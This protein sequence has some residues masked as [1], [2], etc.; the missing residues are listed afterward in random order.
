MMRMVPEIYIGQEQFVFYNKEK[1]MLLVI[2]CG[3]TNTGF[4]VYKECQ[5]MGSWR[6]STNVNRTADEYAVW[7]SQLLAL[8][9]LKIENIKGIIIAN[10]V[11]EITFNLVT[12]CE[13]YF[14]I[15]PMIVGDPE[16]DLGIDIDIHDPKEVG[17]DRIVNAVGALDRYQG[18]MIIVDFGTATTFDVVDFDGT[19]RGGVIA[20]GINLSLEALYNAAARLPRISI[21]EP[22]NNTSRVKI[23][24]V[25]G[26]STKSAMHSGIF[27]GYIGLLEGIVMRIKQEF[28]KPMNVIATG[29]LANIFFEKTD[30]ID[31]LDE[32]I[33]NA[34]LVLI[35]KRNIPW[36]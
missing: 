11:P 14:E 33:T 34:G 32:D 24:N 31:H 20:P 23:E 12:L 17:A 27:W 8:K 6:T 29:G 25:I 18:P 9:G 16:V 7:L 1:L 26:K 19:Y 21:V 22:K 10:V 28:A 35:Y 5:C 4:A 36:K 15:R 13:R 30:S 2:D 3:N